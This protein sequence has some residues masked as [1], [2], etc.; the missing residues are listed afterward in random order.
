MADEGEYAKA[1]SRFEKDYLA[2]L[3]HKNHGNVEAAAREAGM[4]MT[5]IYRKMKKYNIRRED[6]V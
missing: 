4:N 1:L 3:L 6:F 5:S 2:G